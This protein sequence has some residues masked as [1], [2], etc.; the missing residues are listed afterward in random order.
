M[1]YQFALIESFVMGAVI[2]LTD[3]LL[4]PNVEGKGGLEQIFLFLVQATI[5]GV[6]YQVQTE[7]GILCSSKPP[8]GTTPKR[9]D[10]N[11]MLK[12]V[13]GGVLLYVTD[14]IL[15]PMHVTN[16]WM[17]GVKFVIQGSLVYHMYSH[18][19]ADSFSS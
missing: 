5:L 18:N 10:H 12:V 14:A 7:S 17:Q 11:K 1:T 2:A 6:V 8:A 4:R 3:V 13:F 16:L 19:W 15:R 9:G